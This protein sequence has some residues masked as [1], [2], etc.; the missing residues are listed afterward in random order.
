VERLLVA[1]GIEGREPQGLDT[2]FGADEKRVYAFVEVDNPERAP[3]GVTVEFVDPTGHALP[4]IDLSVGESSRW[5]TWA[6]TRRAHA[7]GTWQAVVR[8]DGGR[9]LASTQFDV[10][11]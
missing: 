1:R 6:F 9:V 10:R 5:R 4:P 7:P 2:I 3:G 11:S 8:D